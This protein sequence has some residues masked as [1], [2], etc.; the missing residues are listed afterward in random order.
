MPITKQ[1]ADALFADVQVKPASMTKEG[2]DALFANVPAATPTIT[3]QDAAA[4]FEGVPDA[5]KPSIGRGLAASSTSALARIGASLI[6]KAQDRLYSTPELGRFSGMSGI[7]RPSVD[8]DREGKPTADAMIEVLRD[9]GNLEADIRAAA[10]PDSFWGGTA[11]DAGSAFMQMIPSIGAGLVTRNP[12]IALSMMGFS[13]YGNTYEESI[14]AGK[15]KDQATQD[16]VMSVLFELGPEKLFG[17]WDKALGATKAKDLLA[18]MA[19]E[20]FSEVTTEELSVAYELLTDPEKYQGRTADILARFGNAGLVGAILGGGMSSVPYAFN[21]L[22]GKEGPTPTP[23]INVDEMI[24]DTIKLLNKEISS[25]EFAKKYPDLPDPSAAGAGAPIPAPEAVPVEEPA[26]QTVVGHS[27]IVAAAINALGGEA[28]TEPVPAP[29]PTGSIITQVTPPAIPEPIPTPEPA[30]TPEPV[31]TGENGELPAFKKGNLA[32]AVQMPDGT[33]MVRYRARTGHRWNPWEK[34]ESFDPSPTFGFKPMSSPS[35]TVRIPGVGT[36]PI[37]KSDA[38]TVVGPKAPPDLLEVIAAGAGLNRAAWE[39]AGVDPAE[40]SRKYGINYLFRKNGGMTPDTLR[41]MMQENDGEYLPVDSPDAPSTVSDNDAIDLVMRA[42]GGE[43]IIG[44]SFEQQEG[45]YQAA[46]HE[47]AQIDEQISFGLGIA[48]ELGIEVSDEQALEIAEYYESLA[49]MADEFNNQDDYFRAT[50][51]YFNAVDETAKTQTGEQ[52]VA[53]QEQTPPA[54]PPAEPRTEPTEAGD[55]VI[56]PITEPTG[57]EQTA[58]AVRGAD[59]KRAQAAE[60][61]PPPEVGSGELL[62]T[63][64]GSRAVQTG[65][66]GNEPGTPGIE[67]ATPRNPVMPTEYF[68]MAIKMAETAK[69]D[70]GLYEEIRELAYTEPTYESFM[71]KAQEI[72]SEYHGT[73]KGQMQ[74]KPEPWQTYFKGDLAE[75]TGKVEQ[76]HGGT[77]YEVRLLEGHLEGE[78]RLVKKPPRGEKPTPADQVIDEIEDKD[79]PYFMIASVI[80]RA[81]TPKAIHKV[82]QE[83]LQQAEEELQA[84]KKEYNEK[85]AAPPDT[86]DTPYWKRTNLSLSE[87]HL[88]H[89]WK[90]VQ[91]IKREIAHLETHN[92]VSDEVQVMLWSDQSSSTS[93]IAEGKIAKPIEILGDGRLFVNTGSGMGTYNFTEV[94]PA[95]QYEGET[96]E[97]GEKPRGKRPFYKGIRVKHGKNNYVLGEEIKFKNGKLE[98]AQ[99]KPETTELK[100]NKYGVYESENIEEI[101]FNDDA[102]GSKARIKVLEVAPG[103]WRASYYWSYPLKDNEGMAE[104]VTRQFGRDKIDAEGIPEQT[105]DEAVSEAARIIWIKASRTFNDISEPKAVRDAAQAAMSWAEGKI[106][107]GE[108]IVRTEPAEPLTKPTPNKKLTAI[109]DAALEAAME[110]PQPFTADQ[111]LNASITTF[112]KKAWRKRHNSDD[113]FAYGQHPRTIDCERRSRAGR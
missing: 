1:D 109:Q 3:D 93:K 91:T 106:Q 63:T 67:P 23:E 95:D 55:Q 104:G 98:T 56:L 54:E 87:T 66:F 50:E 107:T 43:R 46:L 86:E 88:S 69:N 105:R 111:F 61:A 49:E 70:P 41:E 71:E 96:W 37:E 39:S 82:L 29:D 101:N 34:R 10:R 110:L 103:E 90:E 47:Q 21:K 112:K 65:L 31:Q 60:N 30:R 78:T 19:R 7:T 79:R 51:E 81:K 44:M 11:Y 85:S 75:Y 53:G 22:T 33:W 76:M 62:A 45:E 16:A 57:T 5:P 80:G 17:V 20:A 97:Y 9:V 38:A 68:D 12:D 94:I 77:F 113:Q 83:R 18:T 4:R 74:R 15:S 26:P 24:E 13:A 102:L 52:S 27:P 14:R 73:V 25:E 84:K 59:E 58:A 40:F 72:Y 36:F 92:R 89:A 35:G 48:E 32:Q 99:P 6:E 2:A 42:L 28:A 100:P 108:N 64:G 8:L